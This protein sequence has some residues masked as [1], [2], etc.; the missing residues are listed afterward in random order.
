MINT[1]S[2]QGVKGSFHEEAAQKYF[3]NAIIIDSQ[4]TFS[5]LIDSVKN[6]NIDYGVIAIENT[7]SGTIHSNFNFT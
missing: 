2:I 5:G 6:N 7:I 4:M 1:I 3:K